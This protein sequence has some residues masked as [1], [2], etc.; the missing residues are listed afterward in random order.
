MKPALSF[1]NLPAEVK[2]ILEVPSIFSTLNLS[3]SSLT[4][5][6]VSWIDFLKVRQVYSIELDDILYAH[7]F[8]I[9][10]PLSLVQKA[11]RKLHQVAWEMNP[12]L[13]H[14][15]IYVPMTKKYGK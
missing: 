11:K 10:L 1:K 8:N 15:Y 5:G 3:S 13:Y 4:R 2:H 9:T 14:Q 12:S 7:M 6:Y